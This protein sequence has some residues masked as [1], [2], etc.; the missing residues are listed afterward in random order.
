[1]SKQLT[2]LGQWKLGQKVL[3]S[4]TE[5][6]SITSITK[7][8]DGRDGTIYVSDKKFNVNGKQRHAEVWHKFYIEVAKEEDYIRIKGKNARYRLSKVKW[9]DLEPTKALE[10][11]KLL[12]D[13]GIIT[14]T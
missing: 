14:L 6:E 8:T 12:N 7:I 5:T 13:N 2:E 9:L 4:N 11:Q 10:V 3:I 1:M